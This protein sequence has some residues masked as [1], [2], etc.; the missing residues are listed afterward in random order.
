MRKENLLLLVNPRHRTGWSA[1]LL[2]ELSEALER[3]TIDEECD[4]L[5]LVYFDNNL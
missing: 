2:I 5:L 1:G 3:G 4:V